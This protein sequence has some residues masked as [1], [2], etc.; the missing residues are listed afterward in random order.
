MAPA[1]KLLSSIRVIKKEDMVAYT[2]RTECLG[3]G[4]FGKCYLRIFNHYKVCIKLFKDTEKTAYIAEAN[5]L[6]KLCHPNL[7]YLFG[8]CIG[9]QPCLVTSFHGFGN[10]SVTLHETLNSKMKT[11]ATNLH[12]KSIKWL[13]IISQITGGLNYLHT[14]TRTI[15]NDIKCDN[16]CLTLTVNEE[17]QAVLVD[18]GKACA[19]M[20][21]KK[22]ELNEEEK[23]LYKLNHSHIAPDLRDGRSKQSVSSDTFSLGRVIHIVNSATAMYNKQIEEISRRCMHY[24]ACIRPELSTVLK[25]IENCNTT[26]QCILHMA[27]FG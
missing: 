15:H 10:E 14:K 24:N 19:L 6:S 9:N 22:Y 5:I 17:I 12:L 25:C 21:G 2:A 26:C 1:P 18:F 3:E 11:D 16:I 8:V 13:E 20:S 7:P 27:N 4:R 23:E